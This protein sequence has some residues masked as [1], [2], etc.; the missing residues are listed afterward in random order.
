MAGERKRR[1]ERTLEG[2]KNVQ[3]LLRKVGPIESFPLKCGGMSEAIS[4]A[5]IDE[6]QEESEKSLD[7]EV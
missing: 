3:G 1:A 6:K 4:P 7:T 2:I 5:N